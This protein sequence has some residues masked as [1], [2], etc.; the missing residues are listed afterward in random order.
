MIVQDSISWGF[1]Q[2]AKFILVLVKIDTFYKFYIKVQ[3]S[4]N[5]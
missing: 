5:L 1:T 4:K 3:R 2:N